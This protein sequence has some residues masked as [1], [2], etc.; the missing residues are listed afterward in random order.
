[1]RLADNAEE[2]SKIGLKMSREVDALISR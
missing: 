2:V 1:V